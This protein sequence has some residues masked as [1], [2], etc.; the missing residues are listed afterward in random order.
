MGDILKRLTLKG[1]F[2]A[3]GDGSPPLA[4]AQTEQEDCPICG[5]RGWVRAD[6]PLGHADFGKAQPCTCQQEV[7]DVQ[8]LVRLQR[9]SNMGLLTRFTFASLDPQG[10][11]PDVENQR[12]FA[13]ALGKA[14]SYAR[15]PRGWLVL[16]GV[17]GCGK[18]HL[19][20][21]VANRCMEQG[22]PAFFVVVPDL[23]D[24]LRATFNPSATVSYDELFEQVRSVP[25]LVLDD[26]GMQSATPWAQE[27]L[28]QILNHRSNA[29]F[30]TVV[31]INQPLEQM[32]ERLSTRL[33]DPRLAQVVDVGHSPDKAL[34]GLGAVEP[35]MRD[36][37]TFG[38]FD[39]RGNSADVRGRETLQHALNSAQNF[40][41]DPSGWLVFVGSTGCGKTHLAVAVANRCLERGHPVFFT[42]V[43]DL[44]DHLRYTFS[45]ESRVTYD[46]MLERIK[47]A[48]L[49]ILDDLGAE[50]STPWAQEKLYQIIVHRYNARLPTILTARQLPDDPNDPVASRLRDLRIIEMVPIA[51]PDYRNQGRSGRGTRGQARRFRG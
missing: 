40:A 21:A 7:S 3:T 6:V 18:T 28:F 12:L 51:A 25:L 24:H 29:Q 31:T 38:T 50:S 23:L 1:S 27:K 47:R 10:R 37:M 26:L 46:E 20:A 22:I 41:D 13:E 39:V 32:E 16:T 9:Y 44:L 43:P 36:H 19:A 11:S 35:Q 15:D 48:P 17:S 14:E 30:P 34:A 2:A 5:G 45:P 4:D 8:R 42:F 49:L 33:L